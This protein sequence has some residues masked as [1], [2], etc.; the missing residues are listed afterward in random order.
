MKKFAGVATMSAFSVHSKKRKNKFETNGKIKKVK[1]K[2]KKVRLSDILPTNLKTLPV[3]EKSPN[4]SKKPLTVIKTARKKKKSIHAKKKIAATANGI[5][6]NGE[7]VAS[8]LTL[9]SLFKTPTKQKVSPTKLKDS[10]S[11]SNTSPTKKS[12]VSADGSSV[13]TV[14][15]EENESFEISQKESKCE[16]ET[17]DKSLVEKN[18]PQE[19]T[20]IPKCLDNDPMQEA[21]SLFKWLINPLSIDK[22]FE[23]VFNIT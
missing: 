20:E 5:S 17:I 15:P 23:Y 21:K 7:T 2:K 11:Q 4:T 3:N 6:L 12:N 9:K 22:F 1:T 18:S 16:E 14:Q 10:Q 13:K 19:D 8:P